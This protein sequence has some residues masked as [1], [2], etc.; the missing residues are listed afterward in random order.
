MQMV[1]YEFGLLLCPFVNISALDLV[2]QAV[3][4]NNLNGSFLPVIEKSV[5]F[6]TTHFSANAGLLLLHLYYIL[7][8]SSS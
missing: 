8:F 1:L 5:V 7:S 3:A 6:C 4:T 2:N